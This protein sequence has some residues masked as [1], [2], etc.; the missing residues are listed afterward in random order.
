MQWDIYKKKTKNTALSFKNILM[1]FSNDQIESK[2]K[3]W[4]ICSTK[5]TSPR[6]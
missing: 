6:L 3:L 4:T 1:I 2:K 5:Q